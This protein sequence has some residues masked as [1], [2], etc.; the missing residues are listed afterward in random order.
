MGS[1]KECLALSAR[2]SVYSVECEYS[3]RSCS[4]LLHVFTVVLVPDV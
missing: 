1:E 2:L 3:D 4:V